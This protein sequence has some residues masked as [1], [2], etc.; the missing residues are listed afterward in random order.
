MLYTPGCPWPLFSKSNVCQTSIVAIVFAIC[1]ISWSIFRCSELRCSVVITMKSS[2]LDCLPM[3][4]VLLPLGVAALSLSIHFHMNIMEHCRWTFH[5][6][7]CV[8]VIVGQVDSRRLGFSFI[9]VTHK[10]RNIVK[11]CCWKTKKRR[12]ENLWFPQLWVRRCNSSL[13][14]RCW[15]MLYRAPLIKRKRSLV[16]VIVATT[17]S[18]GLCICLRRY[19]A[20]VR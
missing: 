18:V 5:A 14:F 15:L 2:Y 6:V 10:R 3:E 17:N 1:V 11:T 9:L 13:S 7:F 12:V 8:L 4:L 16:V 19:F 20:F